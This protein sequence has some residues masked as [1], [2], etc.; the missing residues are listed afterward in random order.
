[1]NQHLNQSYFKQRTWVASTSGSSSSSHNSCNAVRLRLGF[2]VRQIAV[3]KI[4]QCSGILSVLHLN[5]VLND[6]IPLLSELEASLLL[7]RRG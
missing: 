3:A 4:L 5:V 1:M 7:E 2:G 6:L